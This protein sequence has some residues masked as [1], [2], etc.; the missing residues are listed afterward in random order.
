MEPTRQRKNLVLCAALALLWPVL[1]YQYVSDATLLTDAK[2]TWLVLTPIVIAVNFVVTRRMLLRGIADAALF[3]SV[4]AALGLTGASILK[5]SET[6]TL[7]EYL[8][9]PVGIA[10]AIFH[11]RPSSADPYTR[12]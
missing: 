12:P 7:L 10:A 3:L 2:I 4:G 6:V 9:L 1:F 11:Y 5:A 8:W